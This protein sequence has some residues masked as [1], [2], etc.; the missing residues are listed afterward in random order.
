MLNRSDNWNK[1]LG[2]LAVMVIV[3][4]ICSAASFAGAAH[5]RRSELLEREN[6]LCSS[7]RNLACASQT[8]QVRAADAAEYA[9]YVGALQ[10]IG[11]LLGIAFIAWTLQATRA[12]VQ[13]ARKATEEAKAATLAMVD[14]NR[15]A[16]HQIEDERART[17]PFVD[18]LSGLMPV[19][20]YQ[21]Y[22]GVDLVGPW[23]KF[24]I[25]NSGLS[26]A[27]NLEFDF[28]IRFNG[29]EHTE[30]KSIASL[31]AGDV[32]DVWFHQREGVKFSVSENEAGALLGKHWD[33]FLSM[34]YEDL[35][36]RRRIFKYQYKAIV[37][38][39]GIKKPL[40]YA[41]MLGNADAALEFL[42]SPEG[43]LK[44]SAGLDLVSSQEVVE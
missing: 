14:A 17:Q 28:S 26:R 33:I 4:G 19:Q 30:K 24:K 42:Q 35:F 38:R 15:I 5:E 7:N 13:E 43:R 32:Q 37:P 22:I 21:Y 25:E 6:V 16:W 44:F 36:G 9:V 29:D 39:M 10:L 2:V 18:V 11:S 31:K 34:S 1:V 12:S 27:I 3:A 8:S 41:N 20:F 23:V 40:N